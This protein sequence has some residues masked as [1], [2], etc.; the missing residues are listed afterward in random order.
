MATGVQAMAARQQPESN[1]VQFKYF[2]ALPPEIRTEIY[3]Y[4]AA[5]PETRHS[6]MAVSQQI[7][8]ECT[9]LI[10]RR[11]Q[12][13]IHA[14]YPSALQEG[15]STNEIR[16]APRYTADAFDRFYLRKMSEFRLRNIHS[17][18]YN[19][20]RP[21]EDGRQFPKADWS[22]MEE[23]GRVLLS[24]SGS[25]ECLEEV[26]IYLRQSWVVLGSPEVGMAD[27]KIW[28]FV[29]E[30]GRWDKIEQQLVLKDGP[31]QG[32]KISRRIDLVDVR[33]GPANPCHRLKYVS[34]TFRKTNDN[35]NQTPGESESLPVPTLMVQTV[36]EK[37]RSRVRLRKGGGQHFLPTDR[38]R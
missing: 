2:L 28:H 5:C 29:S 35:D 18:S 26:V 3:S 7:S 24:H 33:V 34:S 10:F 32:W 16:F 14:L 38:V 19:V 25:L 36:T 23:L 21:T 17:L 15:L 9:P 30:E 37:K 12:F 8:E 20:A 27:E 22:V 11:L 31:L 6:L 4:I 1:D 13:T